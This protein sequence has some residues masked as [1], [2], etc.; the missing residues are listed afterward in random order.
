MATLSRDHTGRE[1]ERITSAFRLLSEYDPAG[2]LTRQH[3]AA[4]RTGLVAIDRQYR[5]DPLGQL[6]AMTDLARG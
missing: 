5:Y 1:V 6:V 3:G 4:T 2:R